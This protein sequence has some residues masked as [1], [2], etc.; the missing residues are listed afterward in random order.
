MTGYGSKCGR[1]ICDRTRGESPVAGRHIDIHDVK[2]YLGIEFEYC[3]EGESDY[4]KYSFADL[5]MKVYVAEDGMT[6]CNRNNP[7]KYAVI[8]LKGAHPVT[9]I[10][11]N[12]EREAVNP[13]DVSFGWSY[14]EGLSQYTFLFEDAA[15]IVGLFE[16]NWDATWDVA[17]GSTVVIRN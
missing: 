13:K 8:Q 6:L 14:Y 1:E 5:E 11:N 4:Y 10:R 9:D 7:E 17:K 2:A 15:V 12:A 3:R 16:K